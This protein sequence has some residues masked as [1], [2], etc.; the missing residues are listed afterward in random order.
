MS[1]RKVNKDIGR[2]IL[3]DLGTGCSE[4]KRAICKQRL[5]Q[6]NM[7]TNHERCRLFVF[8]NLKIRFQKGNTSSHEHVECA[9]RRGENAVLAATQICSDLKLHNESSGESAIFENVQ[10]VEARAPL[11][12]FQHSV[13]P[14]WAFRVV[15]TSLFGGHECSRKMKR[16]QMCAQPVDEHVWEP[17]LC[18]MPRR[19]RDV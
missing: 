11:W 9:H 10:T 2:G 13:G 16:S 18:T 6:R 4:A 12:P 3:N 19:E 15:D 8:E 17:K 1:Q 5:S 7:S 14:N